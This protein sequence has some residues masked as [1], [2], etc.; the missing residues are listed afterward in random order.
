MLLVAPALAALIA[1]GATLIG[2]G[3]P[4]GQLAADLVRGNSPVVDPRPFRYSRMVDGTISGSRHAIK[5]LKRRDVDRLVAAGQVRAER[6]SSS[7]H[8][9]R[10]RHLGKAPDRVAS[11]SQRRAYAGA[12]SKSCRPDRVKPRVPADASLRWCR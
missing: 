9:Q 7:V 6:S 2:E 12:R 4:A 8:W 10:N 1:G 11:L 3:P 5:A